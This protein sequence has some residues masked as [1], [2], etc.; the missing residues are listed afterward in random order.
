M[1]FVKVIKSYKIAYNL[2]FQGFAILMLTF[3]LL[4]VTNEYANI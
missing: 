3:E 4:I 1:S 2:N